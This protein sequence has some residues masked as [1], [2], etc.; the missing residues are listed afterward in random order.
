MKG[1]EVP[2]ARSSIEPS[3][4]CQT[5]MHIP[6]NVGFIHYLQADRDFSHT[7]MSGF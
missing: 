2:L 1:R 6:E 4:Y 5:A 7:A 3:E